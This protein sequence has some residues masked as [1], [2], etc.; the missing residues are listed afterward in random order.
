[1]CTAP[2]IWKVHNYYEQMATLPLIDTALRK[3]RQ[4]I[5]LSPPQK[6]KGK[7]GG[8]FRHF[9]SSPCTT[10]NPGFSTTQ[11]CCWCC[12]SCHSN[13]ELV[14][15]T[16]C[17]CNAFCLSYSKHTACN[18]LIKHVCIPVCTLKSH[19]AQCFLIMYMAGMGVVFI[20]KGWKCVYFFSLFPPGLANWETITL[21]SQASPVSCF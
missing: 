3:P 20:W 17:L 12:H 18:L 21:V 1:M 6:K 15:P 14:F 7:K 11:N 5:C 16:S 4:I 2:E 19:Q 10:E 9:L 8:D 13:N